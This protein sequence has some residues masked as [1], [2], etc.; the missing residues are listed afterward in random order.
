M[1]YL[2]HIA[3]LIGMCIGQGRNRDRTGYLAAGTKIAPWCLWYG[4][5]P[6]SGSGNPMGGFW[7]DAQSWG[8]EPFHGGILPFCVIRGRHQVGWDNVTGPAGEK[9]I[10]RITL[11]QRAVFYKNTPGR[12]FFDN[13][14]SV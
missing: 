6:T 3:C 10:E 7:C 1:P 5:F 14:K 4:H 2:A 9:P 12:R 11:S 8:I 13:L